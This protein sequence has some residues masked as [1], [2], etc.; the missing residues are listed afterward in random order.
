[1]AAATTTTTTVSERL[2]RGNEVGGGTTILRG[3]AGVAGSALSGSF[4]LTVGRPLSFWRELRSFVRSFVR[5]FV[6]CGS[7]KNYFLVV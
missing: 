7:E 2:P 1:M 3:C 4:Q 6:R 5:A